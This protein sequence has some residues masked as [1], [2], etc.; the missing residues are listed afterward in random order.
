MPIYLEPEQ[1][2]L[3]ETLLGAWRDRPREQ[4][5]EFLYLQMMGGASCRAT[6]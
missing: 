3:F 4:R 5:H 6:I 2:E 1:I